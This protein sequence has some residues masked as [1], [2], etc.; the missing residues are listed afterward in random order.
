MGNLEKIQQAAY[1]VQAGLAA[2]GIGVIYRR[3]ISLPIWVPTLTDE[4]RRV[5]HVD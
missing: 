2:A 1:L 3:W 5:V 4:K